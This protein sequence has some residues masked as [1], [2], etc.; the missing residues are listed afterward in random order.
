MA[1]DDKVILTAEQAAELLPE[2]QY[3]HNFSNPGVGMLVGCDYDR[4]DAIRALKEAKQIEIGG[5]QCKQMKHPI[6]CWHTEKRLT[7]FAADMAKVEA[8]EAA[9]EAEQL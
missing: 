7:F 6:V 8:F 4:D 5:D 3:V 9:L 1:K 2:G